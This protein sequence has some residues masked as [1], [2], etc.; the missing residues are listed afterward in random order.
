MITL[1]DLSKIVIKDGQEKYAL[2]E[3]N[4][5]L[6]D[7]GLVAISG[8]EG[9]G[10]SC[11]L[12]MLSQMDDVSSGSIFADGVDL[13]KL[14][15]KE[16]ENYRTHYVGLVNDPNELFPDLTIKENIKLGSS[17]G[18]IKPAKETLQLLY[19]ALDLTD[20]LNKKP[21][22]CSDEERVIA[23]I[24]RL[25]IKNPRVLLID[26]FDEVF[27]QDTM[28]TVWRYLKSISEKH[29]VVIV[30]NSKPYVDKF[31]DRH[32]VLVEGKIA[33]ITG[34]DQVNKKNTVENGLLTKSLYLRKHKFDFGTSFKLF[35]QFFL[36]SWRA[37]ITT[38]VISLFLVIGFVML[39]TLCTF[40]S[41]KTI[42]SS[43]LDRGDDYIEFYKVSETGAREELNY[44]TTSLKNT[45]VED[46]YD[47]G[48]TFFKVKHE[49]NWLTN[50]K[51]KE[52]KVTS[53]ITNSQ[54]LEAGN[55]KNKNTFGQ[56]IIAGYYTGEAT[57]SND[58]RHIT[59]VVISDYIA[60]LIIRNGLTNGFSSGTNLDG[61][62]R[63][64][65][66]YSNLVNPMLQDKVNFTLN[67]QHFNI[68]GIYKTDF[69][70]FV[71]SDLS[72]KEGMESYFEYN[73][74]NVYSVI[75]VN[76]NFYKLLGTQVETMT[77]N[78][79]KVMSQKAGKFDDIGQITIMSDVTFADR[80]LYEIKS[81][82]YGKIY[83]NTDEIIA[84]SNKKL[85]DLCGLVTIDNANNNTYKLARQSNVSKVMIS[86]DLAM[87]MV[88]AHY[89]SQLG[90]VSEER[91]KDIEAALLGQPGNLQYADIASY[92]KILTI[93][94]LTDDKWA[95]VNAIDVVGVI[96]DKDITNTIIMHNRQVSGLEKVTSD[97]E[98]LHRN[99]NLTTNAIIMP[100]E[101][102]SEG[103]IAETIKTMDEMG[104][105]V[106]SMAAEDINGIGNTLGKLMFIFIIIAVALLA[107]MG[108]FWYRFSAR[109]YKEN[110]FSLSI[111][112]ALGSTNSISILAVTIML[113]IIMI[114]TFAIGAG[115][116]QIIA[117]IA[118]L[119]VYK[120][121][122][123]Q[124]NM[125]I[126]NPWIVL[127]AAGV[128]LLTTFILAAQAIKKYNGITVVDLRRDI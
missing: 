89:E 81:S 57:V 49:V 38:S 4:L 18:R 68:V 95:G 5:Q 80:S 44:D 86:Y 13:S 15:E 64:A 116:T 90:S 52:F 28:L 41:A 128:M 10:K 22:D 3:V 56:E 92:L 53:F 66:I 58:T 85:N 98:V 76:T 114:G 26:N 21:K 70:Q 47:K 2:N 31:A 45:I 67:G 105:T 14:G 100:V 9:A 12:R 118:N 104:Y 6:G 25:M 50:I 17:F 103:S 88:V 75:H 32:I 69:D 87:R 36:K 79:A 23:Q 33:S 37:F 16:L 43:S 109:V 117:I 125:F 61:G 74:K 97:F 106:S 51:N 93:D 20:S 46:L 108:L 34:A 124:I 94:G 120:N 73:L 127:I 54:D 35:K 121:L 123:F 83:E 63:N 39:S 115:I 71:N 113:I 8:N 40:D 84:D 78:G 55:K 77:I 1:K 48:L 24:A 102:F 111:L 60:E 42:A 91:L 101:I 72:V 29:L 107:L 126:I 112:K 96:K 11:L 27:E 7:S 62:F 19:E 30:S 59:D 119:I 110:K 65:I 82:I 122:T 99:A